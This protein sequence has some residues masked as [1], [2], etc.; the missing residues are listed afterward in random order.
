MLALKHRRSKNTH[1]NLLSHLCHCKEFTFSVTFVSLFSP[2]GVISDVTGG[3]PV[4]GS[5]IVSW[6][7]SN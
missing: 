2:M 5:G 6:P 7:E 4:C 3:N 1:Y